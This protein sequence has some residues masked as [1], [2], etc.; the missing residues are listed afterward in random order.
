MARAVVVARA[1]IQAE[2]GEITQ[3][4]YKHVANNNRPRQLIEANRLIL[5]AGINEDNCKI[6]GCG[7]EEAK[8]IQTVLSHQGFALKIFSHSANCDIIYD[9]GLGIEKYIYLFHYE[10]HYCVLKSPRIFTGHDFYCNL[11]D[12]GYNMVEEHK[13]SRRCPG[14]R[15][16]GKCVADGKKPFIKCQDC[17]R[18]FYSDKCYHNHLETR[19]NVRHDNGQPN[20]KKQRST[21]A[22]LCQSLK[23][24]SFCNVS[25]PIYKLKRENHHCGQRQCPTCQVWH[26]NGEEHRCYVQLYL[27][28][29]KTNKTSNSGRKS[30]LSK[31]KPG[32]KRKAIGQDSDS[33][34]REDL[35]DSAGGTGKFRELYFDFECAQE[36]HIGEDRV[37]SAVNI[38]HTIIIL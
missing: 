18:F 11:C 36:Q 22:S 23:K 25:C 9:G 6:N 2:D 37:G 12:K 7:I 34:E 38:T 10:R 14:C 29:K 35:S 4:E 1:R 3:K 24:C 26:S 33:E 17:R 27:E 5:E 31:A 21:P 8:Q 30:D 20:R 15:F 32:Q 28:K 19:D 16:P 13:C